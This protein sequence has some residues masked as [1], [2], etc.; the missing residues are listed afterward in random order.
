MESKECFCLV[1]SNGEKP[2]SL[3]LL[4]LWRRTGAFVPFA[5]AVLIF[6]GVSELVA[7]LLRLS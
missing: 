6:K 4:V 1:P 5:D 7:A 2:C 3:L